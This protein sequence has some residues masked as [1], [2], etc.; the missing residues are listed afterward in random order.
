MKDPNHLT[1]FWNDVYTEYHKT[2]VSDY[3][4]I[5]F[6]IDHYK[7]TS[8]DPLNFKERT[9]KQLMEM[10][11]DVCTAYRKVHNTSGH[12]ETDFLSVAKK[13][14]F[15]KVW[16]V[17]YL[18]LWLGKRDN[19]TDFVIRGL[20]SESIIYST[21]NKFSF[22]NVVQSSN[23]TS[24]KKNNVPDQLTLFTD[25]Y[26]AINEQ[27]KQLWEEQKIRQE[28]LDIQQM[29]NLNI[30]YALNS[31]KVQEGNLNNYHSIVDNI[32]SIQL[33]LN[34]YVFGTDS[35]IELVKHI[36]FL[37]TL[38]DKYRTKLNEVD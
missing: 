17:Y 31:M 36:Q 7:N 19:L 23:T 10:F 8:M 9:Q 33:K 28:K 26:I 22:N 21:Q 29:K 18:H 37:N 14:A 30:Q 16:G 1:S 13:K 4:D 20:P 25:N 6:G 35:H 5:K 2:G 15:G 32:L 12:H 27:K 11:H 3:D 38:K 34:D 24:S